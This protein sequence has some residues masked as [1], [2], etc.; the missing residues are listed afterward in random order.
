MDL[1]FTRS[2]LGDGGESSKMAGMVSGLT[3]KAVS[4]SPNESGLT[5]THR[6]V[7]PFLAKNPLVLGVFKGGLTGLT[8]KREKQQPYRDI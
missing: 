7:S 1:R 6:L 5:G 2:L 3:K 4:D 8:G